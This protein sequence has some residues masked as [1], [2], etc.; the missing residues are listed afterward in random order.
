M[1][2]DEYQSRALRT[3][4]EWDNKHDQIVN[5]SLGLA[6]EMGEVSEWIKHWLLYGADRASE[7]GY[8][9]DAFV[10]EL[11]DLMW[12]IAEMCDAFGLSMNEVAERNLKKLAARHGDK[13]SGVG[14]RTGEGA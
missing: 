6:G 7:K 4:K 8:T 3:M 13:F 14:D 2:L 1:T 10:K 9:H 5:A 11:G 12:Y